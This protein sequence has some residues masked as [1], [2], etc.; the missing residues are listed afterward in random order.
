MAGSPP[1]IATPCCPKCSE[2]MPLVRIMPG[3][4]GF[5]LR[6]FQ[7][8]KCDEVSILGVATEPLRS[9]DVIHEDAPVR[10]RLA[11]ECKPPD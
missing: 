6:K 1:P 5:D 2:P 8:S 4:P 9:D 3:P 11:G 10:G 7:C